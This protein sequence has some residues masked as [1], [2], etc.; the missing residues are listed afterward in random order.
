MI[1]QRV[2][3]RPIAVIRNICQRIST[4]CKM[5]THAG[6]S[7]PRE[8]APNRTTFVVQR[9]IVGNSAAA[10]TTTTATTSASSN[11]PTASA[12]TST[13][14]SSFTG[15]ARV[16]ELRGRRGL[17]VKTPA[18]LLDSL[19]IST[20]FLTPDLTEKLGEPVVSTVHLGNAFSV[21]GLLQSKEQSP[22]LEKR[23]LADVFGLHKQSLV[24]LTP[25]PDVASGIFGAP[26]EQPASGDEYAFETVHGRKRVG[27]DECV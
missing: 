10:T 12:A 6:T 21:Q 25:R 16:G 2:A 19:G 14:S 3:R 17:T 8:G 1:L 11:S 27:I 26:L 13:S 20:A 18:V 4:P 24:F 7:G 9:T 23:E 15:I 22:S 5:S